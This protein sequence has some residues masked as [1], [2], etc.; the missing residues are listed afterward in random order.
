MFFIYIRAQSI[1]NVVIGSD[2]QQSESATHIK[3]C[4]HFSFLDGAIYVLFI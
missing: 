1:N 3:K 4:M 2:A